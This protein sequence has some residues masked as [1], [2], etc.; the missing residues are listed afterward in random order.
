MTF[1]RRVYG[2]A[3]IYGILCLTPMF[4]LEERVGRDYPPVVTHPEY[5][6]GFVGV[7]LA[8]QVAFLIIASDPSRYR[9]LMPAT[10]IEKAGFGIAAIW[11]FLQH[12]IPAPTLGF[13]GVDLILFALFT[14]AFFKTPAPSP[15]P[16]TR[17]ASVDSGVP[18]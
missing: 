9:P 12:R 7:S 14:A 2:L 3:G 6:Y 18:S 15:Q 4:F 16:A 13:A 5:F 11:L 10:L 8:W 1:A 17:P